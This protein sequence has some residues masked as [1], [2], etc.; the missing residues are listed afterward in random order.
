MSRS[1]LIRRVL[2]IILLL[3]ILVTVVKLIVGFATGALS[4]LADGFHS[5]IDSSSN[6]IGLAGLWIASR[7]PDDNHPYGH[8]KYESI[9][10]F[11]I[12][13]MLLLVS[14]EIVQ[15]IVE[16]LTTRTTPNISPLDIAIMAATFFV[17]L[18]VVTYETRQ[19]KALK[20]DILLADAAHTRTDLFV[21]VSVVVSLIAARFGMAWV[22]IVVAAG[23]VVLI[24]RVAFSIVRQTSAVLTDAL[25]I[26]PQLIEK[27]AAVVPG[28]QHVHRARSRGSSDAAYVDVHVRV[29]PAMSTVQ[30]HAIASEVER[31]LK[32]DLPNIVDAIVHI[33]PYKPPVLSE[34][35]AITT[36]ARAEADALGIGIHDLHVHEET[37]G[38]YTLEM[39]VEVPEHLSLGEAHGIANNLETRIREAIPRVIGVTTHLEPLRATVPGEEG[40][41]EIQ[42]DALADQI[43][44]VANAISGP[45]TAHDIQL[46]HVDGHLTTSIHLTL[47]ASQPLTEAHAL[48]EEVERRVTTELLQIKRVVVHVEP[49]EG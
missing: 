46:H 28:V 5:I 48:A 35:Q 38:G 49:P 34:W 23:V 27:T 25:V 15:G 3:N 32:G 42:F 29:D 13:G 8:R 4:V 11:A 14:W 22:D 36:R 47:P 19:G 1:Q 26:D 40:R 30:A 17:N 10:T 6:I 45:G 39:H 21:T 7:P 31:R 37:S 9:A 24:V 2:F 33:E 41:Y 12:G 16:R 18:A 20:S 43:A 44:A